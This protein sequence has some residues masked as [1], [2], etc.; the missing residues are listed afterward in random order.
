MS[1]RGA[2]GRGAGFTLVEMVIATTVFT[3]LVTI[4]LT[5]VARENS[6]FQSAV[7]RLVA[8]RNARYAV[9]RIEQDLRTAG[10]NLPDAQPELVYLDGFVVAFTADYATNLPS[11]PFAVYVDE[12]APGGQVTLPRNAVTL[13]GTGFTF[14]DTTYDPVPGVRSPAELLIFYFAP[15][16]S[17]GRGDDYL[18]WRQ[19]NDGPPERVARNLLRD[20]PAH[21]FSYA[22]RPDEGGLV[23]VPDSAIPLRHTA[24]IH[25][26]ADDVG[27]A[28]LIDRVRLVNVR[29]RATNGLQGDDEIVVSLFRAVDLPNVGFGGLATC[30]AAPVLGTALAARAVTLDAGGGAIELSWGQA[31]DEAGGERDVVRYVLWRRVAGGVDWGDPYVSIPAGSSAYV[32]VDTAIL[33][34]VPYEFALAAQDC[35]PALSGVTPSNAVTVPEG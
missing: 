2:G 29:L 30:G 8:L 12:D 17:T 26:S 21:F 32:Y 10:I 18:L 34:G 11:D 24:R 15:D 35:T 9:T 27:P 7:R 22:M 20:G 4:S 16:T 13:P 6:A 33:P 5:L 3:I 19:V 14:P 28:A 1:V 23:P 31:A 25:G